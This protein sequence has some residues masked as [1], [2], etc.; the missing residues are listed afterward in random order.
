MSLSDHPFLSWVMSPDGGGGGRCSPSSRTA[1]RPCIAM[2]RRLVLCLLASRDWPPGLARRR[3]R[4]PEL[5]VHE[6]RPSGLVA[7]RVADGLPATSGAGAGIRASAHVGKG[8]PTTSSAVSDPKVY[9]PFQP[10]IKSRSVALT[11]E[12]GDSKESDCQSK[13]AK[14]RRLPRKRLMRTKSE[15]T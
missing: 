11:I 6:R 9:R 5:A 2:G 10:R 8:P 7:S 13:R 3:Q 12:V 1:F 14:D 4:P 15:A